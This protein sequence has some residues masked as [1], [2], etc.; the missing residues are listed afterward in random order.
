MGCKIHHRKCTKFLYLRPKVT[1]HLGF[2]FQVG[3][4][5]AGVPFPSASGARLPMRKA[6][7]RFLCLFFQ[8]TNHQNNTLKRH[9]LLIRQRT[10]KSFLDAI[11]LRDNKDYKQVSQLSIKKITIQLCDLRDLALDKVPF[12]GTSGDLSSL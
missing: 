9:F 12:R 3:A 1:K 4:L 10:I 2:H 5:L 7:G 11:R 6:Y 8:N